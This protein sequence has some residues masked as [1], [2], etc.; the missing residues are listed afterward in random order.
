VWFVERFGIC[1]MEWIEG[2][3]IEFIETQRLCK[4]FLNRNGFPEGCVLFR[5]FFSNQIN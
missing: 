3:V 2:S 5:D 4:P 1:E